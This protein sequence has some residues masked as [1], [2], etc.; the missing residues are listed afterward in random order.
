MT[1]QV[2]QGAMQQQGYGDA[3]RDAAA[4]RQGLATAVSFNTEIHCRRRLHV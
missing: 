2:D 3:Q 1:P 4:M